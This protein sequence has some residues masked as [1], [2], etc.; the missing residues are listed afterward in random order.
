A[1]PAR[2]RR[3]FYDAGR[4][5]L[6]AARADAAGCA[7]ALERMRESLA[8]DLDHY[9]A[10]QL[11]CDLAPVLVE[12]G[13]VDAARREVAEARREAEVV[14]APLALARADLLAAALAAD[15]AEAAAPLAAALAATD[16]HRL[17]E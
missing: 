12:V 16:E 11:R 13:L 9:A 3:Y 2:R 7:A 10:A 17:D 8:D 1:R 14:R 5:A 4:A 15:P 6:A